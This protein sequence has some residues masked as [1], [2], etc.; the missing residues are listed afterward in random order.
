MD[1]EC[2]WQHLFS[3]R[4]GKLHLQPGR[5]KEDASERVPGA[6]MLQYRTSGIAVVLVCAKGFHRHLIGHRPDHC[7]IGT[8]RYWQI[9]SGVNMCRKPLGWQWIVDTCAAG[10]FNRLFGTFTKMIKS[11]VQRGKLI[12]SLRRVYELCHHE[13]CLHHTVEG[14]AKLIL[15][16]I[17]E[18]K[19]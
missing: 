4:F 13:L 16:G 2:V 5:R 19:R 17:I 10:F 15:L 11:K 14:D 3:V 1:T 9:G 6:S 18:T 8:K 7:E 12:H